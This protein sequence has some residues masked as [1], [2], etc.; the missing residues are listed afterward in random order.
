MAKKR[1]SR[2]EHDAFENDEG[3][4]FDPDSILRN[5]EILEQVD[6][7]FGEAASREMIERLKP[8]RMIP[9]QYQPRPILPASIHKRLHERNIDCYKAA[10]E[11]IA[12]AKKDSAY[13][14]RIDELIALADTVEDH[15]QIKPITGH[16]IPTEDGDFI[17]KIE[18]GERRFWGVCLKHVKE[19]K[20]EEP[21]L[22]V[23]VVEKPSVER[24]IIENRHAENPSAV[25]QAR[26]IASL[27]IDRLNVDGTDDF[28]DPYDYFRQALNPKG[29]ERLPK[30]FWKDIDNLM[31]LSKRRMQQMLSVL[32]LP[33]PLLEKADLHGLSYR[34]ISAVQSAPKEQ[35]EILLNKAIADGLSGDDI[36]ELVSS[37]MPIVEKAKKKK[38]AKKDPYKSAMRGLRSFSNALQVSESKRGQI[39]D[40]L[41]DEIIVGGDAQEYVTLLEELTKLVKARIKRK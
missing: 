23:E 5:E 37:E 2:E 1:Y 34:V 22:R 11:W 15:G 36:S 25:A 19:G 3:F 32:E 8:S 9:D 7:I 17:F 29:R 10:K 27:I 38:S 14:S 24:Q 28:E 4:D 30:G 20:K 40:G 12:L 35:Q 39:L 21:E 16:W 18:T 33:S 26:E 6:D 13:R 31:R 41:A